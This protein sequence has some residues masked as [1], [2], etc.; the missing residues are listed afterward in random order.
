MAVEGPMARSVAD[1]RLSLSVLAG[2][3]I[4]DPRS[5]DVPLRGPTPPIRRAAL[6]TTVAGGEIP[7]ETLTEIH[8]AG[9][10]LADAG[11]AVEA[12][13]PPELELV[14]RTWLDLLSIDFSV[15][16][17]S[18]RALVTPPV[19]DYVMALCRRSDARERPNSQIHATRS[20]LTRLWSGF[21]AR[22]PVA[23]GPTWTQ[24]PWPVDADLV[25]GAGVDLVMDTT[26]FITPGNL[27]GLPSVALPTG[28]AY[29]LPTGIQIYADLWRED[30]CLE[31][32]EVIEAG[33][34]R[35]TPIDPL[36]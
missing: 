4:R 15:L 20:R 26:R 24:L 12:A 23:V 25:P 35:P 30:L 36:R 3:D 19:Y 8:R 21:F 29:G 17:P 9:R 27:L 16:M 10:I 13:E 11:W 5:V 32:A 18:I 7:P 14:H 34:D 1:L 2:R 22:Y 28:V 33:V 6:V 31:A